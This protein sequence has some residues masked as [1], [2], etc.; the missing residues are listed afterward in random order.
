MDQAI[1]LDMDQPLPSNKGRNLVI[2]I[3]GTSNKFGDNNTNVIELFSRLEDSPQ[4]L[5]YY[6]SGVGTVAKSESVWQAIPRG[7]DKTID[8]AIA[9][10]FKKVI[11]TAYRWLTERYQ[12]NDR[13]YLFVVLTSAAGFSRGAY[14]VRVLAAMIEKVGLIQAGN[15]EQIPFAFDLYTHKDTKRA[16]RFKETFSKRGAKVHFLGAWDTVSSVGLVGNKT[17]PL[18]DAYG[19]IT[20]FRHAL[21]LDEQRVKFIPEC[22]M[23]KEFKDKNGKPVDFDT[24]EV[25]LS[26]AGNLMLV[27]RV[28]EVWFAG[29]HS[30][31][32]GGGVSSL[33]HDALN[34]ERAPL[35]WMINEAAM[36]GLHFTQSTVEWKILNL[37]TRKPTR[38]LH[39]FW[40]FLEYCP[41]KRQSR[42]D[43]SDTSSWHVHAGKSR[44][45]YPGQKIH[46]SVAF[47]NRG[48]H[49][50]AIFFPTPGAS[51]KSGK[52]LQHQNLVKLPNPD[53]TALGLSESSE[54]DRTP[55]AALASGGAANGP[56]LKRWNDKEWA[57]LL[58][59]DL[60]DL[61]AE[62]HIFA[63]LNVPLSDSITLH[64]LNRLAFLASLRFERRADEIEETELTEEEKNR[65]DVLKSLLEREDRVFL[66]SVKLLGR[67]ARS[68][69]PKAY[70]DTVRGVLVGY[71]WQK[72][73]TVKPNILRAGGVVERI[74]ELL[75]ADT[76]VRGEAANTIVDIAMISEFQ[77]NF[78]TPAVADALVE[79][80]SGVDATAAANSLVALSE[81]YEEV[82]KRPA[83]PSLLPLA[84]RTGSWWE[85]F[86]GS[87]CGPGGPVVREGGYSELNFNSRLQ[88]PD[89]GDYET[90][91]AAATVITKITDYLLAQNYDKT[92]HP[93]L[94]SSRQ[95][96]KIID[97]Q[98]ILLL[99]KMLSVDAVSDSAANALQKLSKHDWCRKLIMQ[100][101]A[102]DLIG[103]LRKYNNGPAI[104]AV[105][106]LIRT[107]KDTHDMRDAILRYHNDSFRHFIG[108]VHKYDKN[109]PIKQ[110]T[111]D[112]FTYFKSA[113]IKHFTSV[114]KR[115][116]VIIAIA[117]AL[118]DSARESAARIL[119]ELMS[120]PKSAIFVM[121]SPAPDILLECINSGYALDSREY[122]EY[123]FLM[124]CLTAIVKSHT[125]LCFKMI[126]TGN[127]PP[128]SRISLVLRK[129]GAKMLFNMIL[130]SVQLCHPA[131]DLL[132][133]L[134]EH[135]HTANAKHN[136]VQASVVVDDGLEQLKVCLRTMLHL[137][138]MCLDLLVC[139]SSEQLASITDFC[140]CA[141][142]P[143]VDLLFETFESLYTVWLD[144]L[145]AREEMAPVRNEESIGEDAT[146]RQDQ[147]NLGGDLAWE[148][149]QELLDPDSYGGVADTIA[150]AIA[151]ALRLESSQGESPIETA[152]LREKIDQYGAERLVNLLVK[153]LSHVSG[154][155]QHNT[156]DA[157]GQLAN[158]NTGNKHVIGKQDI[159][160]QAVC[161]NPDLIPTLHDLLRK[162]RKAAFAGKCLA[163]LEDWGIVPR[164]TY[165]SGKIRKLCKKLQVSQAVQTDE[166]V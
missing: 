113:P 35:L 74:I 85:Y 34:I 31:V 115:E 148:P 49:P 75:K 126:E 96:Y 158:V 24:L 21:A 114:S 27:K 118:R 72:T 99:K 3:D 8:L 128:N 47:K 36:A 66:G 166:K 121:N 151:T 64:V 98:T 33:C 76:S 154:Q 93:S 164:Y 14:Q 63:L 156:W 91:G 51:R 16:A 28:K 95:T 54:A 105:A 37:K 129:K 41:I 144:A 132:A 160:R 30:D 107:Q 141:I 117:C 65:S 116:S 73:Q 150:H 84:H 83:P 140:Q 40:W 20:I 60:F 106:E 155:F 147:E 163:D 48:Y 87:M 165:T 120:A 19:H 12:P 146:A 110:F 56:Q 103:M 70:R 1:P 10:N 136:W 94:V 125:E 23:R 2:C 142:N 38:S 131:A 53:T 4:Q 161:D 80:L 124:P 101:T 90:R 104:N 162:K 9:W 13:I 143:D 6:N 42:S 89:S 52:A 159:C 153:R 55:I 111:N 123:A 77:K 15:E 108:L 137:L 149:E 138:T 122:E 88:P 71:K 81:Y 68:P 18:T 46:A 130:G 5:N 100:E 22:L 109:T 25:K 82:M 58:E 7:I 145:I 44:A 43:R 39:T 67:L 127:R 69:G 78:A 157:I 32:G 134:A 57:L 112:I 97:K 79:M 61:E 135:D 59:Q 92:H 62:P 86:L 50:K 29:S 17:L 133:A 26:I 139:S 45:I 102:H 119:T 11:I 152:V